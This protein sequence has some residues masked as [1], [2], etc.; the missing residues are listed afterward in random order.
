[1][2]IVNVGLVGFGLSGKS[3]IAPFL[4]CN[5][6]Y[7]LAAIRSSRE[8]EIK[9]LYPNV[10]IVQHEMELFQ[11]PALDLI[12]ISSPNETHFEF[13]K[14]ALK[15]NKHVLIEKPFTISSHE[16]EE[17]IVLSKEKD[18]VLTVFHNRRWDGD[19]LTVKKILNSNEL[20]D[21]AEFESHFDRY[22]PALDRSNWRSQ[23]KPGG[24]MLYDLGPHLI[25][26][27]IALF[28]K[29]KALFADIRIV[30]EEGETDDTFA[31]FLFYHKLRVILKSSVLVKEP[32]PRFIVHG[33][34]GSFVK[35]GL[36]PQEAL[37]RE[38]KLP[39]T[40]EWG[41][42]K[43]DNYGILNT[44]SRDKIVTE[45]GNYMGLFDN[46]YNAITEGKA[47]EITPESALE[48]IRIIEL[49]FESSKLRKV[50]NLAQA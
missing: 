24:G 48:T 23:L 47:L 20:G 38:G 2:K 49:A 31:L 9:E 5:P 11:N 12:I 45:R 17:L 1:M 43:E 34:K 10:E 3:F 32:G 7:N 22:R 40:S 36:D 26:Q 46:V 4:H 44:T 50:I 18:K 6:G 8:Q 27:A 28:G 39:K 13:A 21:V 29:P 14:Q 42:D 16:A 30:R 19:F 41:Q 33:N 37:L 35:Y 25:D 15:H